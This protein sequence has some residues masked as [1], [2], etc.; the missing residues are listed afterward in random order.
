MGF[1]EA[2]W[3]RSVQPIRAAKCLYE[4]MIWGLKSLTIWAVLSLAL[5]WLGRVANLLRLFYSTVIYPPKLVRN[6]YVYANDDKGWFQGNRLGHLLIIMISFPQNSN[7]VAGHCFLL[8]IPEVAAA[9][10]DNNCIS[11]YSCFQHSEKHA[12]TAWWRRILIHA[13][14]HLFYNSKGCDQDVSVSFPEYKRDAML[15]K[16]NTGVWV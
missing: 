5:M 9:S 4:S 2:Y 3:I 8:E 11:L 16:K 7:W 13:P 6:Y 1:F 15:L 12:H 10:F 14:M